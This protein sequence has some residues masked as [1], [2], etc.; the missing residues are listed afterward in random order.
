MCGVQEH[1][2]Y[3]GR[4]RGTTNIAFYFS[5]HL[6]PFTVTTLITVSRYK[7][8]VHTVH[9]SNYQRDRRKDNQRP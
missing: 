5:N 9:R 7:I 6:I 8:G 3:G 2:I 1:T 4:K